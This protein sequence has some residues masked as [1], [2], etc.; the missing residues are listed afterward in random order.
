MTSTPQPRK[1]DLQRLGARGY[2]RKRVRR[3]WQ[4]YFVILIPVVLLILFSYGPMYGVQIAFRD[5]K[6]RAGFWDSPWVGL[7]HFR[8][9]FSTASFRR[10]IGNTMSISLYSLA[11][12]FPIPILLALMLNEAKNRR[13]QKTVQMITYAPHFISMVVMCSII[14]LVITS[15]PNGILN[16][17]F[18][19][20]GAQGRTD[21]IAKPGYFQ[22]IYVW[23]GI[24]QSMG[25][26][27]IIYLAALSGIDP[28]LHEAA[29]VDGASKARKIWHIDIPGIMPTIIIL[30]V[31]NFGSLMNVGHEKVLLLQNDLNMPKSDII[32]TYVYRIGLEQAH[33]SFSAAVG[34]FNSAVNTMLL[35]L[36]NG[37]AR[38][39]SETSLF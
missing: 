19:L 7:K 12:G 27:S 38:R 29:I 25:Y 21:F 33:Y 30:L 4:L 18:A 2:I 32:S 31:L 5:F 15:A 8:Q 11:A 20:F 3:H 39:V 17:I 9:F 24:W 16:N 10:L 13:F 22:T 26:N 28:T 34:L 36:V 37:I 35:I 1:S 14:R 6:I 23:S